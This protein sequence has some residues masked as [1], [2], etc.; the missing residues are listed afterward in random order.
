MAAAIEAVVDGMSERRAA[1]EWDIP[2][3]SIRLRIAK[4]GLK[5]RRQPP[6]GGPRL[7][8]GVVRPALEAVAR[9][10]TVADAAAAAGIGVS[11]LRGRIREHVWS[12]CVTANAVP[13]C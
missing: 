10:A 9:G 8:D 1:A 7:A 12:C 6:R 3:S 4:V 13:A 11:T 2:A 5:R